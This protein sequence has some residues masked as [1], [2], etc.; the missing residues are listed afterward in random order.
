MRHQTFLKPQCLIVINIAIWLGVFHTRV[1]DRLRGI[2]GYA[3]DTVPI[4]ACF[5]HII[6]RLCRWSTVSPSVTRASFDNLFNE[7]RGGV[8]HG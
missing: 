2:W 3:Q 6:S 4:R 7:N 5:F 1:A 8:L